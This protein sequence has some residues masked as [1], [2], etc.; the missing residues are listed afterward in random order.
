MRPEMFFI[1]AVH[2]RG[3]DLTFIITI[4]ISYTLD[5]ASVYQSEAKNL[6]GIPS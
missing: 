4:D 6:S 2:Y 1:V 5:S 3:L